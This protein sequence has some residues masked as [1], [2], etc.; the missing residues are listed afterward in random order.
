MKSNII[1]LKN[2]N[3]IRNQMSG[4]TKECYAY[5]ARR[6]IEQHTLESSRVPHLLR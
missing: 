6:H 3:I 2:K 4:S 5:H 1:M